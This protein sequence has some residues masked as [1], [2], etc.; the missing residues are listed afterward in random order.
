M[1][2][3]NP[4]CKYFGI[5]E[6]DSVQIRGQLVFLDAFPYNVPEIKTDIMSPHY[7]TYYTGPEEKNEKILKDP[8][9]PMLLFQSNF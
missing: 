3:N 2:M 4:L 8:S 5:S 9:K 7:K 1:I 6:K